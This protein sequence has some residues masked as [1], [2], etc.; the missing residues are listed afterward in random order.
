VRFG[1]LGQL[2]VV[3]VTVCVAFLEPL[4]TPTGVLLVTTAWAA[5]I[6]AYVTWRFPGRLKG[7]TADPLSYF[8]PAPERQQRQPS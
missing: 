3:A 8:H 7:V 6:A 5:A 2:A 1:W 4:I